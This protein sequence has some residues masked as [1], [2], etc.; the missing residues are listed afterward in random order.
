MPREAA[1]E[2]MPASR[3]FEVAAECAANQ[4]IERDVAGSFPFSEL[5]GGQP[6][7]LRRPGLPVELE[8]IP[9][10]L[11]HTQLAFLLAQRSLDACVVVAVVPGAP[12]FWMHAVHHH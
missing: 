10:H 1:F 12:R 2:V 7:R 4:L 8:M 5:P 11:A 9:W 6:F 3:V